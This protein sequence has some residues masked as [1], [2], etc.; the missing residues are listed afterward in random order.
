MIAIDFGLSSFKAVKLEDRRIEKKKRIFLN[1]K[2]GIEKQIKGFLSG[3]GFLKTGKIALT[4]AYA[5]KAKK[6][7]EGKGIQV[8]LVNE[9]QATAEGSTFLSK[10]KE[11][12]AVSAGTGTAMISV[13]K[14]KSAHSG[15]TALGGK[16]ITGLNWL[17]T[18]I[19]DF[20]QAESNTLKGDYKKT[21]LMLSDVYP[22][23][24]GALKGN[25]CVSHFGK[26][27]SRKKQDLSAGIFNLV[28]QGISLNA[29]CCAKSLGHKKIVFSGSLAE[30]SIFQKTFSE[31]NKVFSFAEPIF[32]KEAGYASAVGAALIAGKK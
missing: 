25:V 10:E 23:G 24:I 20:K 3:T 6:I 11:F 19:K 15:G 27:S 1:E 12:L 30:S 22:K 13:K 14:N 2:Q 31:C 29:L 32:L 17:I 26:I 21:D 7:I 28:C 18:G 8:V 16:T 5:E 9:I 4:G